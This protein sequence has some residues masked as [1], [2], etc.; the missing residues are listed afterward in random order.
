M[1]DGL[2]I[3]P[4]PTTPPGG[5]GA[6][7]PAGP[8]K[9]AAISFAKVLDA[10]FK[11]EG[12]NF[13]RHAAERMASR[14]IRFNQA[15]MARLSKAV[16]LADNK[17]ARESL[18]FINDKALIVNIKNNTVVTVTDQEHLKEKVFTKIDSAVIA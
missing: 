17:G 7:K 14:G 11:T 12:L 13:S 8:G 3:L 15:E 18:V 6:A 1:N 9:P 10:Q 16:Q 4:R 5:P 2:F